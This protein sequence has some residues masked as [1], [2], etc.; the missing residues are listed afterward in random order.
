MAGVSA[1]TIMWTTSHARNLS[2]SSPQA[3]RELLRLALFTSTPNAARLLQ[4]HPEVFEHSG[5]SAELP[6]GWEQ[7]VD[8][9]SGRI[10]YVNHNKRTTCWA[11]PRAIAID[12]KD[13]EEDP[14]GE[15]EEGEDDE[16]E[17]EDRKRSDAESADELFEHFVSESYQGRGDQSAEGEEEAVVGAEGA[18]QEEEEGVD[19]VEARDREQLVA[20]C[21][22][23]RSG[24]APSSNQPPSPNQVEP[25]G[26]E[27]DRLWPGEESTVAAPE[28]SA[29]T[30]AA[31]DGAMQ[32][33]HA[34][35]GMVV[36]EDAAEAKQMAEAEDAAGGAP[37]RAAA[38]RAAP[39]G[40]VATRSGARAASDVDSR[41]EGSATGPRPGEFDAALA[42][43]GA[44]L[45]A[46]VPPRS[47]R[48]D[49]LTAA[50]SG[51]N[52][53]LEL[54]GCDVLS[55]TQE[56]LQRRAA[57]QYDAALSALQGELNE[58]SGAGAGGSCRGY[59]LLQLRRA[60]L[61]QCAHM[62]LVRERERVGRP[63]RSWQPMYAEQQ[64]QRR[65]RRGQASRKAVQRALESLAR[66]S[67]PSLTTQYTKWFQTRSHLARCLAVLHRLPPLQLF[68]HVAAQGFEATIDT[69]QH[70]LLMLISTR[71]R[72]VAPPPLAAPAPPPTHSTAAEAG[73][74]GEASPCGPPSCAS[75]HRDGAQADGGRA[76]RLATA[77]HA[78][79]PTESPSGRRDASAT[80]ATLTPGV[81][82]ASRP[83]PPAPVGRRDSI[84][85]TVSDAD[86]LAVGG[87]GSE[88]SPPDALR[89]L[90]R[91]A[92]VRGELASHLATLDALLSASGCCEC[93]KASKT[94]PL[95]S[96]QLAPTLEVPAAPC[97]LIAAL[98]DLESTCTVVLSEHGVVPCASA[99]LGAVAT[100][101]MLGIHPSPEFPS[102]GAL[103]AAGTVEACAAAAVLTA[104]LAQAA[105]ST[106]WGV[107]P[108]EHDYYS[109]MH[110]PPPDEIASAVALAAAEAQP[111]GGGSTAGGAALPNL[112]LHVPLCLDVS[113]STIHLLLASALSVLRQ[114]VSLQSVQSAAECALL[115]T[116]LGLLRL[117]KVHLHY[118]CTCRLNLTE[119]GLNLSAP[120][121]TD[122]Q[123]TDAQATNAQ[124]TNPRVTDQHQYAA[125]GAVGA[126]ARSTD[127][128]AD[129]NAHHDPAAHATAS[130]GGTRCNAGSD[131]SASHGEGCCS[132]AAD[133]RAT[134]TSTAVVMAGE[135][136][137]A[138]RTPA[139]GAADGMDPPSR[140]T[141]SALLLA[142]EQPLT[143]AHDG[144]S[145]A[146]AGGTA[147]AEPDST[148]PTP[149]TAASG[150]ENLA[151]GEE[152]SDANDSEVEQLPGAPDDEASGDQVSADLT[153]S[154]LLRSLRELL[155][156]L[157]CTG[158]PWVDPALGTSL[159]EHLT[160]EAIA[161][162]QVGRSVFFPSF[163]LR[164]D[165]LLLLLSDAPD[166]ARIDGLSTGEAMPTHNDGVP[167]PEAVAS[168]STEA[169]Q[170][171]KHSQSQVRPSMPAACALSASTPPPPPMPCN[172]H[173]SLV[174]CWTCPNSARPPCRRVAGD[175]HRGLDEQLCTRGRGQP[176]ADRAGGC[177]A[178]WDC[179]A[180]RSPTRHGLV[181][182]AA[183]PD[184]RSDRADRAVQ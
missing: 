97:E 104:T 38:E 20:E 100:H 64:E 47:A 67:E 168:Q 155:L 98:R 31:S 74:A 81:R 6:A 170:P 84:S 9:K 105:T 178:G 123:A 49:G 91:L 61:I 151:M 112:Q 179:D 96:P 152:F 39:P 111:G 102:R 139:D 85:S 146:S 87:V 132:G 30:V 117:L 140:A 90:M 36:A 116:C 171:R 19:G 50:S 16:D 109:L 119:M 57:L 22:K 162:L 150:G 169:V 107:G 164:R 131:G 59:A 43:S 149:A 92:L 118:V 7:R 126:V 75:P 10:F 12:A 108:W 78:P 54:L 51:G 165:L 128:G 138:T 40:D 113:P 35:G 13:A 130:D 124:A 89:T 127:A 163:S 110:D 174:S 69:L 183:A 180:R 82:A 15:A 8:A 62:G 167:S 70:K 144:R 45:V 65:M 145:C 3:D 27:G 129:A 73:A 2:G 175:P 28:G 142:T 29:E 181:F 66:H 122:A 68:E 11:D 158:L 5:P 79:S 4:L 21:R 121:A 44:T 58:T 120:I 37:E 24:D 48:C 106:V 114:V 159:G 33:V 72:S 166:V 101:P 1:S 176:S 135:V 76:G 86:V 125:H 103:L 147:A 77:L 34:E 94:T 25:P 148:P 60:R 153:S 137:S 41:S 161:L 71:R 63:Q 14:G 26:D 53:E 93:S 154:E 115:Y 133:A 136:A 157:A 42:A 23:R 18:A 56:R 88:R 156:A 177:L 46:L 80:S 99:S 143:P 172:P 134:A 52:A 17:A 83:F 173:A 55:P 184:V 32:A 141:E 160:A 95:T 182:D